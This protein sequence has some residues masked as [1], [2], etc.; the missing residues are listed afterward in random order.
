MGSR[1]SVPNKPLTSLNHFVLME[2]CSKDCDREPHDSADWDQSGCG[3]HLKCSPI[4]GGGLSDSERRLEVLELF[5]Q[6][7]GSM[8]T[9][10]PQAERGKQHHFSQNNYSFFGFQLC[11]MAGA[12]LKLGHYLSLLF[13]AFLGHSLFYI[14]F[15]LSQDCLFVSFF[16]FLDRDLG[17]WQE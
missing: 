8:S 11:D 1:G 15:A 17:V 9:G 3:H 4:S 14:I 2:I 10:M 6:R 12:Y 16:P 5:A 13:L 7:F